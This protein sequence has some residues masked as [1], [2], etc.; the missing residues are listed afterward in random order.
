MG[1]ASIQR[2]TESLVW[3]EVLFLGSFLSGNGGCLEGKVKRK[4]PG[5]ANTEVKS[6]Q[7]S[8]DY[9]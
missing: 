5:G 8:V 6:Q 9:I 7:K 4:F 1:G 2:K 3:R